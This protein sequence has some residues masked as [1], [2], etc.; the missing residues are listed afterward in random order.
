METRRVELPEVAKRCWP[1]ALELVVAVQRECATLE[2]EDWYLVGGTALAADWNHRTST[3]IDILI[4]PGL[5]MSALGPDAN[6]RID[7]L[8]RNQ[9][10]GRL[11]APDQKLSVEYQ[12]EGKVDIFSSR[13]QLPGHE[14]RIEIDG[15]ST[16]RLSD[17]Q[18]FAGKLRRAIE[19]HAVARD[20]FDICYA[21][22]TERIGFEQ[23][24]NA[25]TEEEQRG[26]SGLW[27][28]AKEKIAEEADTKLAGVKDEDRIPPEELAEEAS[29]ALKDY[30]YAHTIIRAGRGQAVVRTRTAN[31]HWREYESAAGPPLPR[32]L[33]FLV[34]AR[35]AARDDMEYLI[36]AAI[37]LWLIGRATAL[38]NDEKDQNPATAKR[39]GRRSSGSGQR[40]RD[41]RGRFISRKSRGTDTEPGT[42]KRQRR[43]PIETRAE[44]ASIQPRRQEIGHTYPYTKPRSAPSQ[45]SRTTS[46]RKERR[47]K[48]VYGQR[49]RDLRDEVIARSNGRCVGCGRRYNLEIHQITP[50]AYPCG[51]GGTTPDCNMRPWVE[52]TDLA[53]MCGECHELITEKRR[54]DRWRRTGLPYDRST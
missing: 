15:T 43:R 10:G 16:W 2:H 50:H 18:I 36:G 26:I 32:L 35:R 38:S 46:E 17:A 9:G 33:I 25:L 34:A 12:P 1:K 40:P 47:S 7:P 54:R 30:L 4:A 39:S 19:G 13:R 51:C 28:A 45:R 22:K 42:A 37:I 44:G 31:G 11:E 21:A 3:D 24:L 6:G 20:L 8:I 41:A 52:A 53:A 5:S 49:F 14:E 29:K 48:C 23:A 27:E